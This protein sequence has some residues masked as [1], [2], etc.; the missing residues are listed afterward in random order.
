MKREI[1]TK[2]TREKILAQA[3]AEFAVKGYEAGSLNTIS[4]RGELSKGILYHYFD[5]KKDLYLACIRQCFSDI[6]EYLK[7]S[8]GP[9]EQLTPEDYFSARSAYF[10]S[11][12]EEAELFCQA[13][14][15]PPDELIPDICKTRLDFDLFNQEIQ[16]RIISDQKIR[17]D[18]SESDILQTFREFQDFLNARYHQSFKKNSAEAIMMHEQDCL[19]VISVFLYGIIRRE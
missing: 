1:K 16:K 5:S 14:L 13:V 7:K 17:E 9:V 18:L 3:I 4:Q 19:A 12:P 10:Q 8:L 6:T 2:Q 11:H 15:Y